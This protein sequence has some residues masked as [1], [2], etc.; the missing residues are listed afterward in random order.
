MPTTPWGRLA[1]RYEAVA[2]RRLLALDGGGIRGLITLEIL[3]KIENLLAAATRRG[4]EF[5]LCH[6]FDYIAGTSTGAIVATGLALGMTVSELMKFY[7]T[8]GTAMFDPQT[9]L[10]RW[11]NPYKYKS[12]P[13][14]KQLKAVFGEKTN[15]LPRHLESLLLIVTRNVHTDSPWPIS[16]NP[17]AKYNDLQRD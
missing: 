13:L 2:P 14:A 16:S 5:R 7:T 9:L 10:T 6:F 4:N 11:K 12:D 8:N 17:L 3:A 1:S 15:L